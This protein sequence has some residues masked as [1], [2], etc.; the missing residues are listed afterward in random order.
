MPDPPAPFAAALR[1]G[2]TPEARAALAREAESYRL[3]HEA[4]L[5]QVRAAGVDLVR[6]DCKAGACRVCA[7]YCGKA[8]SLSGATPGSPTRRRCRSARP[9]ATRSTC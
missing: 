6:F 4:L 5:E 8:Y 2:W 9:A 3:S 7:K 1:E